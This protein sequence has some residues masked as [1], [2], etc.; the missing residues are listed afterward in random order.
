MERKAMNVSIRSFFREANNN[1]LRFLPIAARRHLLFI[2][3]HKRLLI[4]SPQTFSEK[5]QWRI[6][7]DRRYQIAVGGDKL[8]MKDLAES[9]YPDIAVPE[10]LWHGTEL[11]SIADVD[12]GCEWVLKPI[13]GTGHAAFGA[14]TLAA[15]GIDLAEVKA[16]PYRNPFELFGEWAYG[17]ARPGF[18][19]ERRIPTADGNSP[20]DLRF[21]VFDGEVQLIQVDTPRVEEVARRFYTPNW[22][23]LDVRQG[24][25]RLGEVQPTPENL[26]EMLEAAKNIGSGYDFVR[27]DLYASGRKIYF[28]EITP[29]PTA[30]LARWDPV[31][32]D[33]HLGSY[34]RLPSRSTVSLLS[35]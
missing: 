16:W 6:I 30:G 22:E 32:F 35:Q 4:G 29:Y 24:G 1:A 19:I 8:A 3:S 18:L 9:K 11:E 7:H 13:G 10:T 17:Q 14:G 2:R 15:S 28:G 34:W 21:F 27:V 25:K 33:A 20:A 5:I 23:P 12:W 31:S 26:G